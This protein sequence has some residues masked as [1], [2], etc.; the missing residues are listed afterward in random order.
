MET[1]KNDWGSPLGRRHPRSSASVSAKEQ[2]PIM[3]KTAIVSLLT[4]GLALVSVCGA[5]AAVNPN[6]P[7]PY[8]QRESKLVVDFTGTVTVMGDPAGAGNNVASINSDPQFTALGSR[9]LK[10]DLTDVP[11]S[12]S[13]SYAVIQLPAPVDIQG[14]RV[15]GMDVFIPD[16]SIESSWYQFSLNVTTTNPGDDTMT[17]TKGYSV[18][19]INTVNAGWNH[20]IWNLANGTDTKI[21]QITIGGHSGAD[22]HGPVYVD[23]IRVYKG[24]FVGLQPDEQ[25]IFGFDNPTDASLFDSGD[26]APITAN[27]DKPFLTQGTGSLKIDIMGLE[28]RYSSSFVNATDLGVSFD[29]SKATAIHLDLFVPVDS[30]SQSWHVLGFRVTGDAGG[31]VAMDTGGYVVGQ[32]NTLEIPLNDAQKAALGKLTGVYLVRNS[33]S[34]YTWNGPI[35]IDNLRAVIPSP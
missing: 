9:S 30:A 20:L 4:A 29:L 24:D 2:E 6:A 1:G 35:Y 25:L 3:R 21:T 5:L 27:T 14:Y 11:A 16:G 19:L 26:G 28:G 12:P 23:N 32:W 13:G 17:T 10:L 8:P 31:T 18:R 34:A 7:N 33:D 15:L 22:F